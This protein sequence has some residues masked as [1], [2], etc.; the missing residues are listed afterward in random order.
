MG[1]MTKNDIVQ[2]VH[3]KLGF[4]K[5]DSAKLVDSV[6]EIMKE[7]LARGEKIKI[8]GFGS[9]VLKEKKA[10]NSVLFFKHGHIRIQQSSC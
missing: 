9:F 7:S 1:N 4:A 3:S 6:F 10:Q 2:N 5:K 8:S